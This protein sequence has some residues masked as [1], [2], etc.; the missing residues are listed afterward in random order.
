M[1]GEGQGQDPH[2]NA[3]SFSQIAEIN[4]SADMTGS[5]TE[6]SHARARKERGHFPHVKSASFSKREPRSGIQ[7]GAAVG[8]V[9]P[10]REQQ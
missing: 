6:A 7:S 10:G 1:K 8:W 2:A 9:V 4:L 3:G 5:R